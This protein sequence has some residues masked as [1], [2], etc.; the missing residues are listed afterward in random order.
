MVAASILAFYLLT[1][2]VNVS[3]LGQRLSQ[4]SPGW[5]AT[6]LLAS[7]LPVVGS[8][9]GF[10]AFAPGRL[11]FGQITLVQLATSFVNLITPASAGGLALNV[12]YLSRRGIPL[13]VAV[14][15]VGL[16]Q[17]MSVLVTAVAL[18]GLLAASGRSMSDAPHVPWVLPLVVLG[19]AAVVAVVLRFW[20]RGRELIT[21]HVIKPFREAGPQLRDIVTSKKRLAL[22]VAAHLTVTLGF[23]AVLGSALAAFD[24]SAPPILMAAVVIGGSAI[25]GAVPVPGGIGAAEL[26]LFSGLYAIGV[27]ESAALSA[28]L[29]FR[30]ITFWIRVPIG[31]LALIVLRRQAAV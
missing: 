8:A 7:V 17:T 15:V 30:L 29:L 14:A 18:T 9:A 4:A 22:A 23:V 12:R 27:Q 25:A 19:V 3:D 13:A 20:P 1:Q 21:V 6:A 2:Q 24:E 5:L 11:P 28:A 26:A 10:L 31:W 16:V